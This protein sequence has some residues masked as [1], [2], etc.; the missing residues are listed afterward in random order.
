MHENVPS[1]ALFTRS[2]GS[3]VAWRDPDSS[4]PNPQCIETLR[5]IVLANI[6]KMG[7]LYSALFL[8]DRK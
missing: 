5:L 1:P 8:N 4:I 2:E 6:H 3:N 7:A